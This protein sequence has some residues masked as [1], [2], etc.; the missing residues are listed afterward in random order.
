MSLNNHQIFNELPGLI[1]E[2]CVILASPSEQGTNFVK[3]CV[4]L[5]KRSSQDLKH[6]WIL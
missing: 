1:P 5:F 2:R 6:V 4:T 3:I